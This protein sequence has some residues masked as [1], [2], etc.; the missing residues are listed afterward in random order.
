MME[1]DVSYD[2]FI[3]NILL[4]NYDDNFVIKNNHKTHVNTKCD[5]FEIFV[6]DA[7]I[8]GDYIIIDKDNVIFSSSF[9]TKKSKMN[10]KYDNVTLE[11]SYIKDGCGSTTIIRDQGKLPITFEVII[12]TMLD[13]PKIERFS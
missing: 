10:V 13:C 7:I 8:N 3:L 5:H 2:I 1:D 9:L 12:E 4:Q 6:S 11:P